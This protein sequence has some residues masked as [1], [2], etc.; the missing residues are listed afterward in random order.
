MLIQID[1][2]TKNCTKRSTSASLSTQNP[3]VLRCVQLVLLFMFIPSTYQCFYCRYQILRISL[4]RIY[5]IKKFRSRKCEI[6]MFQM[7]KNLSKERKSRTSSEIRLRT[8][9][10]VRLSN[11]CEKIQTRLYTFEPH[12]TYPQYFYRETST[13]TTEMVRNYSGSRS[14]QTISSGFVPK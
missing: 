8:E 14:N 4:R 10:F 9:P 11:L 12:E 13:E 6:R 3:I 2:S 1:W 5:E 7:Q